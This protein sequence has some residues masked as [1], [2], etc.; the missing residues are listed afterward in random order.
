MIGHVHIL[1]CDASHKG[2]TR[3]RIEQHPRFNNMAEPDKFKDVDHTPLGKEI[4]I[5]DLA[6]N[7]HG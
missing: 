3:N 5:P 4:A 7:Y 1:G 2:S 6:Y